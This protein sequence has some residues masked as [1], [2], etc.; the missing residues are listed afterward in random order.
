MLG[1][2]KIFGKTQ[3]VFEEFVKNPKAS[4]PDPFS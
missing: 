2:L 1:E 3:V 4:L